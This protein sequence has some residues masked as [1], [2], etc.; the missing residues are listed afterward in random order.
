M[1]PVIRRNCVLATPLCVIVC[2]EGV[3][4]LEMSMPNGL[5]FAL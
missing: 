1:A 5:T 4:C 3:L 2:S